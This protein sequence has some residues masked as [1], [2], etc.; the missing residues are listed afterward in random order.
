MP[1]NPAI[2]EPATSFQKTRPKKRQETARSTQKKERSSTEPK[3]PFWEQDVPFLGEKKKKS[4]FKPK[5]LVQFYRGLGSML[6]AQMNTSDALYY[7]SKGLPNKKFAAKLLEIR[8]K[9]ANGV[10][11][12]EAFTKADCFNDMTIGLV[13][14][15]SDAGRLDKAFAALAKR[16]STDEIF[17]KK[18]KKVIMIPCIVIPILLGTFIVAQVKIVPQVEGMLSQVKQQP[19]AISSLAFKFSHFIQGYWGLLALLFV[20]GVTVLLTSHSAR[21]FILNLLMARWRVLRK[22]IMSLRQM[23]LLSTICLLHSN[24]INLARSIRVSANTL[25]GTPL[26]NEVI[27]AADKYELSGI[28]IATA[29]SKYTSVDEQVCHMLA[30]GERSASIDDNLQLLSDMYEEEAE[31]QMEA[32]THIVNALVLFIA[33]G[34]IAAVFISSFLPIFL[35]GPRL[36]QGA[37]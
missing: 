37:L 16:L 27:E 18:L 17:K 19:D 30:I 2:Q 33:V 8:E 6:K 28:P 4:K 15:G 5:E 29:F 26:H 1:V 12:K 21:S 23:T 13:Q 9:L 11:I 3:K 32:L 14:S 36:M 24:G 35:M 10:S 31:N 34:L 7:Y 20:V 25:K 22:L